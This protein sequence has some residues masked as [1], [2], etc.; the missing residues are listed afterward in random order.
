[1]PLLPL[2]YQ[3]QSNTIVKVYAW[4]SKILLTKPE[5]T[6]KGSYFWSI[7]HACWLL[8]NRRFRLICLVSSWLH[9]MKT[10]S[11]NPKYLLRNV[12]W[13]SDRGTVLQLLAETTLSV[14]R[15]SY[16]PKP[17][18]WVLQNWNLTMLGITM[19]ICKQSFS[20]LFQSISRFSFVCR[21]FLLKFFSY[22]LQTFHHNPLYQYDLSWSP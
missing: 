1:M 19:H 7:S 16:Y 12:S 17:F 10:V 22:C 2:P 4:K 18:F 20:N 5:E 6:Y 21:T 11:P 8:C 3:K 13:S 14:H 9:E 15:D